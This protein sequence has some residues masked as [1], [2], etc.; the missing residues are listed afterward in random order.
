MGLWKHITPVFGS[1]ESTLRTRQFSAAASPVAQESPFSGLWHKDWCPKHWHWRMCNRVLLCNCVSLLLCLQ[2]WMSK[3]PSAENSTE[4]GA[5]HW[6]CRTQVCFEC[7]LEEKVLR[8]SV[9]V[10]VC[11][12]ASKVFWKKYLT[13]LPHSWKL[14]GMLRCLKCMAE[15]CMAEIPPPPPPHRVTI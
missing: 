13:F 7:A 9:L 2:P 8:Y 10:K 4:H 11:M 14:Q 1:Q 6:S 12:F 3:S 15:K 5:C